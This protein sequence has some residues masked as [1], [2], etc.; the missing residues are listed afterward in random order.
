MKLWKMKNV[1]KKYEIYKKYE[2]R[3]WKLLKLWKMKL[4]KMKNVM[5]NYENNEKWK[6]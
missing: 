6:V 1:I 3:K 2:K 4:W 5:K